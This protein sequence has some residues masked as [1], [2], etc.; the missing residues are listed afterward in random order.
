MLTHSLPPDLA[1]FRD[2]YA[3]LLGFVPPLPAAKSEFNLKALR[4]AQ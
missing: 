2:S 1:A 3:A 4:L